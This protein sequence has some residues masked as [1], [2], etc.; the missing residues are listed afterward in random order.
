VPPLG[1]SGRL[2][3]APGTGSRSRLV[4][5]RCICSFAEP[6][7]LSMVTDGHVDRLRRLRQAEHTDGEEPE[8]LLGEKVVA[9][10]A[11]G[12]KPFAMVGEVVPSL[13]NR[14][15]PF[16]RVLGDEVAKGPTGKF[17]ALPDA[18]YVVGIVV[19]PSVLV[20]GVKGG[21]D[22]HDSVFQDHALAVAGRHYTSE[23]RAVVRGNAEPPTGT[24]DPSEVVKSEVHVVILDRITRCRT[25]GPLGVVGDVVPPV[26][27]WSS[28]QRQFRK[29]WVVHNDLLKLSRLSDS[30]GHEILKVTGDIKEG[31]ERLRLRHVETQRPPL[32]YPKVVY[33]IAS[34]AE[35][36]TEANAH[37]VELGRECWKDS[38]GN[39][40]EHIRLGT[41]CWAPLDFE[42]GVVDPAGEIAHVNNES[43]HAQFVGILEP[44]SLEKS[45]DVDRSTR[46]SMSYSRTLS[47]K[48]SRSV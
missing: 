21:A 30:D 19:G 20:E 2:V 42:A 39:D 35:S 12:S 8:E 3:K 43:V 23:F 15:R 29:I 6:A 7:D 14:L 37:T 1:R 18:L 17:D 38:R 41:F 45:V 36:L 34:S 44:G 9:D 28:G 22:V 47:L 10:A 48:E 16:G 24:V 32:S 27:E 26:P 13:L 33:M 40:S 25:V 31:V 4:T 11:L 5:T 46:S